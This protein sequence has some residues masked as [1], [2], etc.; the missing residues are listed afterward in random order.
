MGILDGFLRDLGLP[1]MGKKRGKSRSTFP[2]DP[3]EI[4]ESVEKVV[5]SLSQ[6]KDLPKTVM[7][8]AVEAESDFREADRA[9]RG[10]KP[11]GGKG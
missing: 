2:P 1:G 5:D 7:D 3:S 9:F 10:V 4:K 8:R 11:R 6:I